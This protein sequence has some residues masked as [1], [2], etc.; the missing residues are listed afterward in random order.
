MLTH[1]HKI[2]LYFI[3][4]SFPK[5]YVA[6]MLCYSKRSVYAKNG[7]LK[8]V[9]VKENGQE[10]YAN[11]FSKYFIKKTFDEILDKV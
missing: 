4:C 5:F 8:R 11:C 3:H 7:I 9:L 2:G 1:M 10:C 6:A